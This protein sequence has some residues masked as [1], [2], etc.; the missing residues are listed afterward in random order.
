M[1]LPDPQ[2]EIHSDHECTICHEP[3]HLP[4]TDKSPLEPSYVIDDVELSCSHHFHQSCILE[5]AASSPNARE[6]CSICRAKITD[7][8]G[9]FLATVRTENGHVG[10][11]NLDRDIEEAEY[12]RAHP[13]RERANAFLSQ[14]A[15]MEFEEAE[16]FLKGE[17]GMG[18]RRPLDPNVKCVLGLLT[19]VP[20]L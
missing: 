4:S 1:P 2:P 13:E 19:P 6:R 3:L 18:D 14:M 10:R 12:F 20:S 5:Y 7:R 16:K 17:D 11:I 15:V 9:R 8:Q